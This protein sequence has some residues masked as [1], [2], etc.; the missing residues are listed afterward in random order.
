[1]PMFEEL[2]FCK[3]INLT[4]FLKKA[5]LSAE[6]TDLIGEKISK[7]IGIAPFLH[8]KDSKAIP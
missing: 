3:F 7:L 1:M 8:N 2:W 5:V 4:F 6:I